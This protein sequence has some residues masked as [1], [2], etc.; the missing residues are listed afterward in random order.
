[1]AS[2]DTIGI[3]LSFALLTGICVR[4]DSNSA[5]PRRCSLGRRRLSAL[6]VYAA[7][8]LF[9]VWSAKPCSRISVGGRPE[10]RSKMRRTCRISTTRFCITRFFRSCRS[11]APAATSSG[12]RICIEGGHVYLL[13]YT[14]PMLIILGMLYI[15]FRR[16]EKSAAADWVTDPGR[17][18]CSRHLIYPGSE[19]H[20]GI[21]FLGFL[22]RCLDCS[23]GGTFGAAADTGVH[24]SGA[25]R[26]C[27]V[28]GPL[29]DPGSG[30]SPTTRPPRNGSSQNH[31]ENMP[32]VGE[33]D[34]SVDWRRRVSA[35]A[36]LSDR[37]RLRG[38]VPAC[39]HRDAMTI[40]RSRMRR[41]ASSRPHTFTTTSLF[42][43]VRA[44]R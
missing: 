44:F 38:H 26:R 28:C 13:A 8:T 18:G 10:G 43:Y 35:S 7:I 41:G 25:S 2:V 40:T 22:G 11:R 3:I 33:E 6:A 42:C 21:V 31:L 37:V 23:R 17:H 12:I 19:R 5:I 15:G 16:P 27:Q 32:L 9:A 1:M 29:S 39:F 14:M 4:G 36:D 24:S 34:T 30:R 20:F